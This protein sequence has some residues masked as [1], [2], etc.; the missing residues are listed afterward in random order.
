MLNV[1]KLLFI[2]DFQSEKFTCLFVYLDSFKI[3]DGI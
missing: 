3:Q 1:H 2:V